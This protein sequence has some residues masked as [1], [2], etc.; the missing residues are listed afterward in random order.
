MDNPDWYKLLKTDTIAEI[1]K[2]DL[3][4][5]WAKAVEA[6]DRQ[7]KFFRKIFWRFYWR[8]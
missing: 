5:A 4:K 7:P 8:S 3:N 1:Y 6:S 2:D